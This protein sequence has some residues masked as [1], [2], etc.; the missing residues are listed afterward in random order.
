MSL[1]QKHEP[2]ILFSEGVKVSILKEGEKLS[3]T[4]FVLC[5][6][7]VQKQNLNCTFWYYT[8]SDHS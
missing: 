4:E 8:D 3:W 1:V 5:L 7:R 2:Q 6:Y